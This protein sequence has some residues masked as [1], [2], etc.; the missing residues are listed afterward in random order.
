MPMIS[1]PVGLTKPDAGV[2][3]TRPATAPETRPRMLGFL[4]IIHS[5]TIH[6]SAA[7]AVAIW[8]TAMAMPALTLAPTATHDRRADHA[9]DDVVGRHVVLAEAMT[10]PEHESADEASGSGVQ[11]HDGPACI[12]ECAELTEPAAA[13]HPMRDRAINEDQPRPHEHHEG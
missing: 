9:V 13:P 10:R 7:A 2:I 5:H 11:M 4:A 6:A 3:A 8:V 12:V 1:A